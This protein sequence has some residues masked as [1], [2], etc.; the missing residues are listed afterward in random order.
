[1]RTTLNKATELR[2]AAN[3]RKVFLGMHT[4]T[5]SV[6]EQEELYGRQQ[7]MRALLMQPLIPSDAAANGSY[8]LIRQH[9]TWLREWL[10]KNPGWTLQVTRE[11]ARLRKIPAC[12]GRANGRCAQDPQNKSSFNRRRYVLL[13][14]MMAVLS[15][16]NVKQLWGCLL[17]G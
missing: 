14:L 10:I 4:A 3:G 13:C 16:Q 8:R 1:M 6:I 5:G 11:F 17:T 15:A 7:A 12:V 9:Q 2:I